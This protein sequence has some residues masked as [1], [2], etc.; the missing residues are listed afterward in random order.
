MNLLD[1]YNLLV[2]K[3]I[4]E[5][6][7]SNTLGITVSDL[8]FR[9][10]RYGHRLPLVLATLDKIGADSISRIDAAE[11]LGLSKREI[12]KLMTSWQIKRPLKENTIDRQVSK[13][14]WE[15]RKKY[16]IDFIAG[17]DDLKG[18]A[19]QAGV[20]TRQ[21]R[22][23]VSSLLEEHFQMTFK[24]MTSLNDARRR[25]LADEIETAENLELAKQQV[26]KSIADG[27]MSLEEEALKRVMSKRSNQGRKVPVR[28]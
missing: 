3:E 27:K 5:E 21:M 15:I 12:N 8:R 6:Q 17:G 19:E 25:R 11:V 26:I 10:T 9:L 18:I 23:W 14:K 13:I 1:V 4:T 28:V 20:S 16:A 22:R 24:D 7:A 2:T